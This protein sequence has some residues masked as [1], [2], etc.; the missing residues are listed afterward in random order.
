MILLA[1]IGIAAA[2]ERFRWIGV[3]VFVAAA[4]LGV[5]AWQLNTTYAADRRNP[6]VYAQTS[7]DLVNLVDRVNGVARASANGDQ[8][9]IKVIT[10]NGD[11]WP[12]PWYLRRYQNVGWYDKAPADAFA[13]I[14]IVQQKLDARYDEKSEHKWIMAG[15]TEL[16]PKVF[17]ELYVEMELW[18]KYLA[19][20]PRAKDD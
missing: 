11:Y 9:I 4:Q 16:R 14:M 12:L 1:G 8:T 6:Y 20:V 19:T 5:Q 7:A 10:G 13:P 2:V 17:L 18:K 3:F 15:M